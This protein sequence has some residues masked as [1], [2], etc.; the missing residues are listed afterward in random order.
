MKIVLHSIF[1]IYIIILFINV[2][3]NDIDIKYVDAN[4]MSD[5]PISYNA[6]I[7]DNHFNLTEMVA[8]Y[9][10]CYH[11]SQVKNI[12]DNNFVPIFHSVLLKTLKFNTLMKLVTWVYRK[13]DVT[14]KYLYA[15]NSQN[16]RKIECITEFKLTPTTITTL[17]SS[18]LTF[19]TVESTVTPKPVI[20]TPWFILIIIYVLTILKKDQLTKYF[21]ACKNNL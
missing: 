17:I 19:N 1:I 16:A 10:I 3:A 5:Y 15:M 21:E 14:D 6:I 7:S 13:N 2:N 11:Q 4:W 18:S 9:S 8:S 12:T 20:S